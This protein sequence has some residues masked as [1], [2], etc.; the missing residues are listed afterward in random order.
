MQAVFVGVKEA[1]RIKGQGDFPS[2]KIKKS[3]FFGMSLDSLLD[4]W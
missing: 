3:L 1:G 4:F 2:L